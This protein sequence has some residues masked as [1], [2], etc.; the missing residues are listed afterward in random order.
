MI[1]PPGLARSLTELLL[2]LGHDLVKL[3]HSRDMPQCD[4]TVRELVRALSK[5]VLLYHTQV[6]GR[7]C[8]GHGPCTRHWGT[9]SH[10]RVSPIMHP[11]SG[12]VCHPVAF[13]RLTP[14][15]PPLLCTNLCTPPTHG[16]R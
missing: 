7:G 3:M 1:P 15:L 6:S 8:Y 9:L 5:M 14:P 16:H 11:H 12:S 4:V 10:S 13:L 2:P